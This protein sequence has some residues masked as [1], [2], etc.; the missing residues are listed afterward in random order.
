[1]RLLLFYIFFIQ[2]LIGCN[3]IR[4][5]QNQKFELIPGKKVKFYF[6]D[7]KL[8]CLPITIDNKQ[9]NFIFDTGSTSTIVLKESKILDSTTKYFKNKNLKL[10]DGTV[11]ELKKSVSDLAL[12]FLDIKDKIVSINNNSV[13][14]S[15][16][17]G[18]NLKNFSGILGSDLFL[19]VE[20]LKS[21]ILLLS[22]SDSTLSLLYNNY[23]SKYLDFREVKSSFNFLGTIRLELTLGN[24]KYDDFLFDT[25]FSNTLMFHDSEE[26]DKHNDGINLK[27]LVSMDFN[28]NNFS[29]A[30]VYLDTLLFGDSKLLVNVQNEV[31]IKDKIL[32]MEFI[33]NFDWILDYRN[34]KVYYKPIRKIESICNEYEFLKD[35]KFML[36]IQNE[37]IVVETI[38]LKYSSSV[39]LGDVVTKIN[40]VLVTKENI[41]ELLSLY[42]KN[43]NVKV[44]F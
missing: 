39:K 2:I 41:C 17:C 44:E 28:G 42:Y 8:I 20:R 32:G 29:S 38:N 1:M 33:K 24:I 18:H 5:N 6:N 34:K 7:S 15:N 3:E 23:Q 21:S 4:L 10:P 22:F 40:D 35:F 12:G 43:P 25:G 31:G 9:A 13:A 14:D 27:G 16:F 19:N 37:K 26:F 36:G 11:V 30:K